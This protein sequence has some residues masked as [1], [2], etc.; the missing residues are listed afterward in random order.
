MFMTVIVSLTL[1]PAWTAESSDN[2]DGNTASSTTVVDGATG[3]PVYVPYL[4][5]SYGAMEKRAQLGF[6]GMRGKKDNDGLSSYLTNP[7]RASLGFHG[8]RGK[9]WFDFDQEQELEDDLEMDKRMAQGFHGMRGKKD[10]GVYQLVPLLDHLHQNYLLFDENGSELE[11]RAM[12]GF[13]GMRGKKDMELS[14]RAQQG[15]VGMRG[16]KNFNDVDAVAKRVMGFHGMRG[17]KLNELGFK[18]AQQGFLGMRGKK[19]ADNLTTPHDNESS[20]E[21]IRSQG[22]FSI[23]NY[24]SLNNAFIIYCQRDIL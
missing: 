23:I 18:R 6:Q 3:Y 17:K 16:K 1:C 4:S 20:N 19:T 10:D 5:P 14:K 9:K 7:K 15:F 8:M 24:T 13:H 2:S 11:K 12:S 21:L 22:M